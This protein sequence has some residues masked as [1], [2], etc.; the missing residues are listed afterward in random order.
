MSKKEND[1]NYADKAVIAFNEIM[2]NSERNMLENINRANKGELFVLHFLSMRNTAT[3]PSELSS[4]LHA[5]T[6]RISAL[7]RSLEKKGQIERDIDKS[8]RRN[9]LVTITEAGYERVNTEMKEMQKSMRQVFTDM[10]ETD[11]VEFIRLSKR[12]FE[13]TQKY[14]PF[15]QN[16]DSFQSG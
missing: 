10:G 13:L 5:S 7:L 6:A 4:A 12:F 15:Q 14:A 3:L 1:L 8:N 11:A 2:S 9:I 16:K